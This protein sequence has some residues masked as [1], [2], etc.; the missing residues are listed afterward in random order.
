M[1]TVICYLLRGIKRDGGCG[2]GRTYNHSVNSRKHYHCA[3]HPQLRFPSTL[4]K[5]YTIIFVVC[6]ILSDFAALILSN[7]KKIFLNS[8]IIN[9]RRKYTIFSIINKKHIIVKISYSIH[10]ANN[11]SSTYPLAAFK[12]FNH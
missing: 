3:T 6:Q 4:Y 5:Y 9:Y 1:I 10:N 12:I 11:R 2:R 7:F 8:I